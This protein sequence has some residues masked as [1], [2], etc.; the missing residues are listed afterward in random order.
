V[1]TV[2]QRDMTVAEFDRDC[3][4]VAADLARLRTL[5]ESAAAAATH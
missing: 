2:R 1:F 3:A 5:V 4:A